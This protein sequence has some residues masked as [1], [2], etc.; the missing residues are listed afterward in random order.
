MRHG[1]RKAT[2]P[3][4]R[5]S[6]RRVDCANLVN[7]RPGRFDDILLIGA[8]YDTMRGSPGADDNASGVAG[9]LELSR[10]HRRRAGVTVCFV[11]FTTRSRPSF[12]RA[13]GQR[14]ARGP[15]GRAASGSLL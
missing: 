7:T 2:R 4:A 14:R 15:P 8:H 11:A 3:S 12:S 9:L 1:G 13:T 10:I 5:R 6:G